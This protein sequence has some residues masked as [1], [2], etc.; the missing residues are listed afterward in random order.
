LGGSALR[1]QANG[2]YSTKRTDRLLRILAIP[3][4]EGTREIG[5]RDS[6]QASQLAEYWNA[7]QRYLQTG[8]AS[9]LSEFRNK[10]IKDASGAQVP[11]LTNPRDL[12]RLGSAGVLPFESLYVRSA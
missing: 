11:L 8:D 3:T 12:D 2:R 1:K 9:A 6:R 5:V 10:T 4:P 7:V